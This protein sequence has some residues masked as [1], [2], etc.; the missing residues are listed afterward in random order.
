MAGRLNAAG[1]HLAIFDVNSDTSERFA[2]EFTCRICSSA[3]Q[4]AQDA[5]I[6]I[7]MLPDSDDVFTSVLGGK[8]LPGIVS[9]HDPG[10]IIIDMSSSDPL[11]SRELAE[12]LTEHHIIE[13]FREPFCSRGHG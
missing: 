6:V 1:Y 4:A 3:V 11:H 9:A 13:V 5:E 7:T 8:S 10:A 2:G 12:I